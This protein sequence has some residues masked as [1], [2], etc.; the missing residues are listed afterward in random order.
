MMLV[1]LLA[2]AFAVHA[3]PQ[4][5]PRSHRVEAPGQASGYVTLMCRVSSEQRPTDCEIVEERPSNQG[6]AALALEQAQR[7][8]VRTSILPGERIVFTLF[9]GEQ[10]T[11]RR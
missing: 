8:T 9:V 10:P 6:L 1:T 2:L 4:T 5:P 7:K 3:D 11:S